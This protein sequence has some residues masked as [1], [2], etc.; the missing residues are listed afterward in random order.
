MYRYETSPRFLYK[1]TEPTHDAHPP[2]DRYTLDAK[3]ISLHIKLP[4]LPSYRAAGMWF[5]PSKA[6]IT[7]S[8]EDSGGRSFLQEK[9][10]RS[11]KVA[12]GTERE[13]LDEQSARKE[14]WNI[15]YVTY[16][17]L[18]ARLGMRT[19]PRLV[20]TKVLKGK[21][22]MWRGG[23]CDVWLRGVCFN[24][25]V[26]YRPFR[27]GKGPGIDGWHTARW[28][29]WDWCECLFGLLGVFTSWLLLYQGLIPQASALQPSIFSDH[30]SSRILPEEA[31]LSSFPVL[32]PFHSSAARL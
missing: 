28:E 11:L 10:V 26:L 15:L 5:R 16:V 21:I 24:S 22:N 31:P 12:P 27:R 2:T 23:S 3:L 13:G 32:I 14:R 29:Y 17:Y 20:H 9:A 8:F 18:S 19:C 4:S 30:T 1:S 25:T 7:C 6:W